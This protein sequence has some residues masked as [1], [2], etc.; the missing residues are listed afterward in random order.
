MIFVVMHLEN[1]SGYDKIIA[2]VQYVGA[3]LQINGNLKI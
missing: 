3:G 1:Q 2:R